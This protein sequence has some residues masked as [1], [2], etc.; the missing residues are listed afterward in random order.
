MEQIQCHAKHP[1]KFNNSWEKLYGAVYSSS[2]CYERLLKYHPGIVRATRWTRDRITGYP[3]NF[4]QRLFRADYI[5]EL[6]Q[7]H[8][9]VVNFEHSCMQQILD[10]R[11]MS[12]AITQI[13]MVRPFFIKDEISIPSTVYIKTPS[14]MRKILGQ[15]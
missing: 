6:L 15:Y 12:K 8:F 7:Y 3:S 4:P 1:H 5:L 14:K 2:A 11:K 10:A 9:E 13:Y